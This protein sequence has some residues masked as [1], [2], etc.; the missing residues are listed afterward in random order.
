MSL[1]LCNMKILKFIV[2]KFLGVF[3]RGKK[4]HTLL[5]GNNVGGL[6]R[7][8]YLIVGMSKFSQENVRYLK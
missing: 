4:G 3:F 6:S 1:M 8:E 2:Q 7:Y 5:Y